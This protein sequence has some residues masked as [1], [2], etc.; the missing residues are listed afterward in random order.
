MFFRKFS[1]N[2]S[3]S[4]IFRNKFFVEYISFTW[5]AKYPTSNNTAATEFSKI[6]SKVYIIFS[7]ISLHFLVEYVKPFHLII[8]FLLSIIKEYAFF[9]VANRQTNGLLFWNSSSYWLQWYVTLCGCL[10]KHRPPAKQYVYS[11]LWNKLT[12]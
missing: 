2:F 12:S 4:F 3:T 10:N 9:R 7:K 1:L 5:Y 11:K 6:P 8:I